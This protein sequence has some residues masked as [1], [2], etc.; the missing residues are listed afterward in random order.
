[1]N[2]VKLHPNITLSSLSCFK[3]NGYSQ[4]YVKYI[5]QDKTYQ[6]KNYL[7]LMC[8]EESVFDKIVVSWHKYIKSC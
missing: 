6:E 7:W 2:Q 3:K 1:M 8:W 5:I 4:E